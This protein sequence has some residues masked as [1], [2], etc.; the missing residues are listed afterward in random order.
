M[1]RLSCQV[2]KCSRDFSNPSLH[3]TFP[4]HPRQALYALQHHRLVCIFQNYTQCLNFMVARFD[5]DL[6]LKFIQVIS[7]SQWFFCLFKTIVA[8]TSLASVSE[9]GNSPSVVCRVWFPDQQHQHHLDTLWKTN[10]PALCQACW[11]RLREVGGVYTL[12][13]RSLQRIPHQA[14]VWEPHSVAWTCFMW[15]P[16]PQGAPRGRCTCGS[17]AYTGGARRSVVLVWT[18]GIPW[19]QKSLKL[20]S[21]SDR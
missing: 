20:H 21:T 18:G 7:H 5:H 17:V 12:Y 1:T 4:P 3:F 14:R 16:G 6:G 8:S 13:W 2:Q 10:S 9:M 11:I 19:H 15:W